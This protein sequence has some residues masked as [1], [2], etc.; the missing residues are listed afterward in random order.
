MGPRELRISV[1]DAGIFHPTISLTL[2][3][4]T[5]IPPWRLYDQEKVSHPTRTH[6]YSI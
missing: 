2:A 1:T 3:G 6:I 5:M 4:S